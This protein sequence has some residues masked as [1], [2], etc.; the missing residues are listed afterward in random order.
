MSNENLNFDKTNIKD[1]S[2][3]SFRNYNVSLSRNL[4]DEEFDAL[5][6]LSKNTSLVIQKS[7]KENSVVILDKDVYIKHMESL[8]N[9]KTKF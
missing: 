4:S 9:D 5:K 3:T 6:N 8:L 1:A 7:D 2:L